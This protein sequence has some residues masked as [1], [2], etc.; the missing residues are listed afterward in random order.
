[1]KNKYCL[2]KVTSFT[3]IK[4]RKVVRFIVLSIKYGFCQNFEDTM[5]NAVSLRKKTKKKQK[6]RKTFY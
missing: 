4:I 3:K 5:R 1:M 2:T 6:R